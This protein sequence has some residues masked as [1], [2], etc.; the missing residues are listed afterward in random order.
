MQIYLLSTYYIRGKNKTKFVSAKQMEQSIKC[1]YKASI[2][3]DLVS[4][5][6]WN[7]EGI[8]LLQAD[9][10]DRKLSYIVI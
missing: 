4:F 6:Q 10:D 8:Y 7:F 2:I 3:F 5:N 1:H 9:Y